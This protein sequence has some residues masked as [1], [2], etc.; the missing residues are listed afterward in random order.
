LKEKNIPYYIH[1][2]AALFGGIQNNQEDAPVIV[3]AKARGIDSVCVSMHKYLG[4]PD[5]KSV[6]VAVE[7]P[8]GKEI[9][10]IGQHDT[11]VSGSRSIPAYALYNHIVEHS[12]EKQTDAYVKNV[13]FFEELL[14]ASNV[15]FYRAE[16]SNIFVMDCPSEMLC[17]QYQL[18]CFDEDESG[19]PQKAHVIIFPSHGEKEM[20]ELARSLQKELGK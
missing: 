14:K 16:K 5:V 19:K 7:K 12:Q 15:E 6:Y 17:E 3:N 20:Q 4:F 13:R 9:A 8:Q 10:Y 11:T 2:D 18:S 1:L